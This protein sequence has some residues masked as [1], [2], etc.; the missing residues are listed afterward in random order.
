V[1]C[2]NFGAANA[3]NVFLLGDHTQV[4]ASAEG[5][6]AVGGSAAYRDYSVAAGLQ[7]SPSLTGL[8]IA[9]N[10][11]IVR[12]FNAG[13]TVVGFSS[14]VTEYSMGNRNGVGGQ[15]L[16]DEPVDFATAGDYLRCSSQAWGMLPANGTVTNDFGT[17]QFRGTD[18][19]LNVFT[20]DGNNVDGN[21]R[22][23]SGANGINFSLPAG[24]FSVV[25][26]L[27]N[28]V[29]FG[30]YSITFSG[31]PGASPG[32]RILW[33]VPQA[34]SF[35]HGGLVI[36]GSIL[37]P[38]AVV[39]ANGSGQLN[40]QLIALSYNGGTNS[41]QERFIPYAGCLPE[42]C[43][44]SSLTI[45]KT[46][47][48]AVTF[49]GA[50]GTALTYVVTITN[51][52][53]AT[54]TNLAIDDPDLGIMQTVPSLDPGQQFT[55]SVESTVESAKAGTAYTNTATAT[56]DQ[57]EAQAASA[58]VEI[59]VAVL[60][61]DVTLIKTADR[62]SALPGD[63]VI[64]TFTLKNNGN[65]DLRNAVLTDPTLGIRVPL[66]EVFDGELF[67]QPFRIPRDAVPGT[68]FINTA[69]LEASNLP[70]PGF[71]EASASVLV[72]EAPGVTLAKNADVSVAFPG[73]TIR[74]T[75]GVTND[76]ATGSR[77]NLT[78]ND[79][80]LG[81]GKTIA[82]LPPNSMVAYSPEFTVP[83]NSPAGSLIEN[84][85]VLV[86]DLGNQ[87]ASAAVR[88]GAKPGYL[89]LKDSDR[90]F[91]NP[92]DKIIY[93][94]TVINTGN[95]ALT[96]LQISDTLTGS[97]ETIPEIGI[98]ET[99]RMLFSIVVPADATN[100]TRIVNSV[101]ASGGGIDP[102]TASALVIVD[103]A[104]VP[105]I[106]PIPPVPPEPPAVVPELR[107][108]GFADRATVLPNQTI[109]FTGF[110]TNPVGITVRNIVLESP[111]FQYTGLAE[112][113]LPG[114]TLELQA[115]FPVPPETPAGTVIT[116]SLRATSFRTAPA[117]AAV[118]VVV[119]AL[120]RAELLLT[121]NRTEVLRNEQVTFTAVTMNTGNIDLVNVRIR[122]SLMLR[123]V[124]VNR[125]LV[126]ATLTGS[127][128]VV[129]SGP[130]GT[131]VEDTA[132]LTAVQLAA[133]LSSTAG[134][135]VYGLIVRIATDRSVV[136]VGERVNVAVTVSNPSL[137]FAVDIVLSQL[138]PSV[139]TAIDGS[140]RVDGTPRTGSPVAG[141]AVGTLATGASSVVQYALTVT[142]EPVGGTFDLSAEA[143][144]FFPLTRRQLRGVSAAVPVRI[145]VEESEE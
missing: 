59:V 42:V 99:S 78:V 20:F 13:N 124:T 116:A 65:S 113:L 4:N 111:L 9:G 62:L 86:S 114:Q 102:K 128:R 23:L 105:P 14:V 55:L 8:V 70:P 28:N 19:A 12:G 54:L 118:S 66:G 104:P 3:Y 95:T 49:T 52:G 139:T 39:T 44:S 125:F 29:G 69:S 38:L 43:N 133:P 130:P 112:Q 47:N 136:A 33:N 32:S 140:L 36:L 35:F 144:F 53:S 58:S 1:A 145:L 81:L 138:V 63:E 7:P 2:S 21:G 26:V 64:Y 73:D 92:G 117:E 15:P 56:S 74:Y 137:S 30:S 31:D 51:T 5:P 16:R 71:V 34:T 108:T 68:P 6:V 93:A 77:A 134:F 60:P 72:T 11:N 79:A 82:V 100:G 24:S 84:T 143:T 17:L 141:V 131:V 76:S 57:T 121:T 61:V 37:A 27:G 115:V 88:V 96:N 67:V 103:V 132:T 45:S 40:G 75:I 83:A 22:S 123:D 135:A 85:A 142:E 10:V 97:I 18:P 101:V 119:A 94:V 50:P 89:L 25:N 109:L 46:V 48:G 90:D 127:A 98:G 41:L 80:F 120:P 91:A 107:V 106:P 110:V 129:A 87:Q 122:D 126:G